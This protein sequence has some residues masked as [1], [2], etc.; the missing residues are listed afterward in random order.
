[1]FFQVGVRGRRGVEQLIDK[2]TGGIE[3]RFRSR[4]AF[5]KPASLCHGRTC[6]V[7]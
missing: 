1:M 7:F 5:P 6:F 4:A 2:C 3:S